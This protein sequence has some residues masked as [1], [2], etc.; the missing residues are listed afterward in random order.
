[1]AGID[2]I[3]GIISGLDTTEMIKALLELERQPIKAANARIAEMNSVISAYGALEASVLA[4]KM[5]CQ[6]LYRRDRLV[7]YTSNVSNED[8]L[9]VTAGSNAAVGSYNVTVSQLAHAHQIAS[10]AMDD[11]DSTSVGTGTITLTVGDSSPVDI[12]IDSSNSTLQGVA[13]AINSSDAGVRAVVVNVGGEDA[14]YRLLLSG[15]DTGASERIVVESDLTGGSGLEFGQVSAVSYGTWGGSSTAV[16]SGSYTGN[17][18]ES[19][20]FTVTS[21]GDVGT[22]DIVLS[23]D[24]GD[25]ISGEIT[26]A[27]ADTEYHV[28]GGMK[29]SLG[30]GTVNAGDTLTVDTT[31]STIQSPANAQLTLGSTSGGSNPIE[32]QSAT[33]TIT[34]V[35]SGV[36]LELDQAAPS[37]TISIDI[38]LD[39]D[40]MISKIENFI[41]RYN[42]LIKFFNQQ[43]SYSKTEGEGGELF[44]DSTAMSLSQSLRDR[45]TGMV[46][47]LDQDLTSL[48]ALGITSLQDGTLSIDRSEL[49]SALSENPEGIIKLFSTSGATTDQDIE[50]RFASSRTRASYPVSQDGYAVNITRAAER[51]TLT[52]GSISSPSESSPLAIDDTNNSLQISVDGDVSGELQIT[53]GSYTSGAE[54][55]EEIQDTINADGSSGT[56]VIVDYVEE[57]GGMG[58]FEISTSTYGSNSSVQLMAADNSIY[59]DI[60][61]SSGVEETGMDVA[62]TINGEEAS[63]NGRVLTGENG[64]EYTD[65]LE[66]LV[67]L[68]PDQLTA[69]GSDQGYVTV[70]KGVASKTM[71][72]IDDIT[73]I[74]G[75]AITGR[76]EALNN[77]KEGMQD[78]IDYLEERIAKKE[79][80]LVKQFI[81]LERKLSEFQSQESF[82]KDML[83]KIKGNTGSILGN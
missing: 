76:K 63:G 38:G 61:V 67:K 60:S 45:I 34:D 15:E 27:E 16:S 24:N 10:G 43:F 36:T 49:E 83:N 39:Q 13:D 23:Y 64:N 47:G 44:G 69:Q 12:N 6:S 59:S 48:A 29:I 3:D 35:I 20:T 68:T 4:L 32:I 71:E 82:I 22:D 28:Y 65:S 25:G 78:R 11:T 26:I 41:N 8:V 54:L 79:K 30:A 19:F 73:S 66:V 70:A 52:G 74:E 58:H 1:M 75:G 2:G 9:S 7:S 81:E 18:N 55:A 37:E 33:N 57:G 50:F 46:N 56:T 72:Y 53:N 80:R 51:A 42:K 77:S 31:S 21:G 62:G 40:D 5:D 17:S 14:S